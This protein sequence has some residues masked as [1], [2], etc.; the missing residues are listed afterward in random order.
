VVVSAAKI[1][2]ERRNG[3]YCASY[4]CFW[5]KGS[6]F[7]PTTYWRNRQINVQL[8][9]VCGPCPYQGKDIVFRFIIEYSSSMH[10][11]PYIIGSIFIWG[12]LKR[13]YFG[14]CWNLRLVIE[15]QYLEGFWF[16]LEDFLKII[17]FHDE[18]FEFPQFFFYLKILFNVNGKATVWHT[19]C[20]WRT[21]DALK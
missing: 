15:L 4:H 3:C 9:P 19:P 6:K 21:Q 5:H 7:Q 18:I 16:L 11:G 10:F 2:Q 14:L 1:A 8:S 12:F 13:W 20:L 17:F